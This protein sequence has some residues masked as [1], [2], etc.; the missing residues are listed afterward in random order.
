[1]DNNNCVDGRCFCWY[2]L[3]FKFCRR[4]AAIS[5]NDQEDFTPDKQTYHLEQLGIEF[6]V[7]KAYRPMLIKLC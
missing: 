4:D 1:M 6:I 5:I 2:Y 7:K 3:D